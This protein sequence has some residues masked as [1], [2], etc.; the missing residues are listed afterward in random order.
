MYPLFWKEIITLK[1]ETG[2]E[3]MKR[4]MFDNIL[5]NERVIICSHSYNF[6]FTT[7]GLDH[8]TCSKHKS[9][10][11]PQCDNFLTRDALDNK[12]TNT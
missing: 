8:K 2:P 11:V 12:I 4:G 3:E 10:T 5:K 9:T 1:G 7:M 6:N